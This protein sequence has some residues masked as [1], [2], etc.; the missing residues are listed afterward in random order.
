MN[1]VKET[2][3]Q[4]LIR[5]RLEH[6]L[7]QSKL[8][9]QLNYTDKSISKWER[10]EAIPPVDVLKDIAD[11]Y[12]VSLDFLVSNTDENSYGLSP[13]V[14][15][16]KTNKLIITLLAVSLVWIIATVLFAYGIM[17]AERSFWVL[18]VAAVPIT[19]IVLLIFNGIWGKRKYTFI[20]ISALIWGALSSIYLAFLTAPSRYNLWAIFIIGI[21]FQIATIL[22]SQLKKNK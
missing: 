13:A 1:N 20:L 21:P 22:W 12:G 10:G 5:L 4:N 18:F 8:A 11:M 15:K 17:F 6:G 3:P 16:E 14:K 7:T 2:L 9:E 19:V